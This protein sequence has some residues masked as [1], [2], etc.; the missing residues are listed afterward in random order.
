MIDSFL[1]NTRSPVLCAVAAACL[2]GAMGVAYIGDTLPAAARPDVELMYFPSGRFL[3]EAS[4]GHEM[5]VADLAW[6]R[7]IQYYGR[8]KQTDQDYSMAGHIFDVVTT[9][10]PKFRNA[11]IFGGLVLA[12]DAGE[13]EKGVELLEKGIVNL[14]DDWMLPFE[15]GFLYYICAGDLAQAHRWFMKAAERPGH[16]ESVER[17]AAFCAART[18]DL[19]TALML[20]IELYENTDNDYVKQ[21]AETRIKDLMKEIQEAGGEEVRQMPQPPIPE[22]K[23]VNS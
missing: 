19:R 6:L 17:F 20:W 21:M 9:L 14:P 16:P 18:G 12:Q 23:D 11:Y 15:A 5:L 13:L 1:T 8:H 7:A 4:L 10:D 2:L 22:K 3:K